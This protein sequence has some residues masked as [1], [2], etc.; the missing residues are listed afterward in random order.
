MAETIVGQLLTRDDVVLKIQHELSDN[1]QRL[2]KT[3]AGAIVTSALEERLGERRKVIHSLS[4]RLK[5]AERNKDKD[6]QWRICKQLEWQRT[7]Y[8]KQ[9]RAWGELHRHINI[10]T[11]KKIKEVKEEKKKKFKVKK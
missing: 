7:R 9:K 2:D 10:K 3:S 4:N 1:R 5:E 11:D 6:K 8:S